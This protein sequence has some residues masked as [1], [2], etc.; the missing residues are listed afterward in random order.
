MEFI[1]IF[2]IFLISIPIGE[3]FGRSKH[4]GKWWTVGLMTCGII[5]GII[6][7]IFSPKATKEPTKGR[8]YVNIGWVFVLL[9][10]I[11]G[12]LFTFSNLFFYMEKYN[13]NIPN[14]LT[15][16]IGIQFI[17]GI[18]SVIIGVYLIK[19]GNGEIVND[20]PNRTT[21]ANKPSVEKTIKIITSE[22]QIVSTKNPKFYILRHNQPL[23]PYTIA[24]LESIQIKEDELVC[25]NGSQDWI[26]AGFISALDHIIIYNPPPLPAERED[27]DEDDEDKEEKNEVKRKPNDFFQRPMKISDDLAEI[28]GKN[29][30]TRTE[31]VKA[32]WSY[33]K[34]NN[35]QDPIEKRNIN[36]DTKLQK[37][38][39]GRKRV[40][41]FEMTKFVSKHLSKL[42]SNYNK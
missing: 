28:V 42:D 14:Y 34:N 21:N 37:I 23:G 8:V 10:G 36:A 2:I 16:T 27:V 3:Y 41:M 22:N 40:S 26:K 5:P 11:L 24:E 6:A 9:I 13:N 25:L 30:L 7:L 15:Q 18:W 33:I 19:L 38:F 29:P 1:L 12:I 20:N 35:L 31:V 39:G 32:L 4:I 17:F